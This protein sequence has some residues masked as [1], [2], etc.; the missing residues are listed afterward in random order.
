MHAG[1]W[2]E[3]ASTGQPASPLRVAGAQM[4]DTVYAVATLGCG[5]VVSLCLRCCGFGCASVWEQV[6]GL[7]L[8]RETSEEL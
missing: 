3:D 2:L 5:V 4:L 8:V 6:L 1:L 7:R